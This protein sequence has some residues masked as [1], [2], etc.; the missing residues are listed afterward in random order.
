MTSSDI[1]GLSIQLAVPRTLSLLFS[2][3][4]L[5]IGFIDPHVRGSHKSQKEQLAHWS[6]MYNRSKVPMGGL[7]LMTTIMGLSCYRS[8]GE[9]LWLYGSLAAFSI[10]PWTFLAIMGINNKLHKDKETSR[11]N[12]SEDGVAERLSKWVNRH[13]VRAFFGLLASV[14]FFVAECKSR[15]S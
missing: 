4:A 3:S 5:Y 8:T 12:E 6:T 10:I 14:L 2:G 15:H 9:K 7:A 11:E 1:T 13:R